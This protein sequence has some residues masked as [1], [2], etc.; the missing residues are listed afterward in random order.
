M[1]ML[2]PAGQYGL[3]N[4]IVRSDTRVAARDQSP[5]MAAHSAS[6]VQLFA[7]IKNILLVFR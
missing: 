3:L 5:P 1:Y 4:V 6:R 2:D 7:K